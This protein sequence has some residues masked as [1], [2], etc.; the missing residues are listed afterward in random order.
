MFG[1]FSFELLLD[2]QILKESKP[3]VVS[4]SLVAGPIKGGGL[5]VQCVYVFMCS[6]CV[7]FKLMLATL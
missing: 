7:Y 1:C 6:Q 2:K 3:D 4:L 5:I